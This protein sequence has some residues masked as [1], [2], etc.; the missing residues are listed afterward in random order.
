MTVKILARI[1]LAKKAA[2]QVLENAYFQL[3][4]NHHS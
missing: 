1:N 2:K 3:R 4:M